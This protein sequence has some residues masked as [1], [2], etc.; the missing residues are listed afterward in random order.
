MKSGVFEFIRFDK[1]MVDKRVFNSRMVNIIKGK[2]T[3]APLKE[4]RLVVQAYMV[5]DKPM[6]LRQSSTVQRASA[7][8]ILALAFPVIRKFNHVG[9]L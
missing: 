3:V 7:R 4:S 1:S 5:K 8:L 6:I 2:T 9:F